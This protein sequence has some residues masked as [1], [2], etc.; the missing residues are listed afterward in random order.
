[1]TKPTATKPPLLN[2]RRTFLKRA[3]AATLVAVVSGSVYRAADRGVFSVGQGDAYE[4]W[5]TWREEQTTGTMAL[6]Q[7]AI[8][9]ANPHNS[10]PW[11][12]RVS[13]TQLDLFAD[14]A[15]N[16]GSIDPFLRE[17]YTG[18]GCALEN[19]V[20]SARALGYRPRVQLLPD[21]ENSE[22]VARIELTPGDARPSELYHAIPN[23]HTNRAAYDT[24][25]PVSPETLAAISA[26]NDNPD[27]GVLWFTSAGER[28]K[29]GELIV[30]ATEALNADAEQL[31]DSDAWLRLGWD[32]LQA[33]RDGITV[34]AQGSAFFSRAVL[35][36]LPNAA[37]SDSEQG[38]KVFL[39]KTRDVHVATAAGFGL[40]IVRDVADNA[41]RLS[42]G[43]FWQR[44]HLWATTQGLAVQPLNQMA[45]RADRERQLGLEPIFG[46]ALAQLTGD[47]GWK[48][49]MPFRIG[50]PTVTA[51]ASPRRAVQEV[52]S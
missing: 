51:L 14:P 33:H 10:Q 39:Q 22:H 20:L 34:D 15:R 45:E 24:E 19:V 11:L 31:R 48:A 36:V 1:M 7:S 23:R 38:A 42:G 43:R 2:S 50:Y 27:V 18:L 40:L 13:E 5:E 3:G 26:L 8:L 30:A 9:A 35:K 4:P 44:L 29:V 28:Q 17:M 37:L 47:S 6:V 41:Q 46:R 25:R 49:L 32:Q 21:P 52:L 12:F 16:I